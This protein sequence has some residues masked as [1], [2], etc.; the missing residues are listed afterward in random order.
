M[1]GRWLYGTLRR[2]WA[3]STSP[4]IGHALAGRPVVARRRE[5]P[6]RRGQQGRA[7]RRQRRRQDDPAAADRRR[8]EPA[9]RERRPLGRTRRDAP[10]HRLGARRHHR[11]GLPRPA[12]ACASARGLGRR[13]GCR[14][15]AHGPRRRAAP[16]GLRA[17]PRAL[18]RC[19]RLRRRGAVGHRHRRGAGRAVRPRASTASWRPCPAASRSGSRSSLAA[20]AGRGAAARRARQLPRRPGQAVARGAAARDGQDRAVR[21]PRPRAARAGRRPDRHRRGRDGL[22]ARRRVR[23]LPRGADRPSTNGWPSCVGAGRRS[24]RG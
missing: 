5:L 23:V 12:G 7:G 17:R 1:P 10:V 13:A 14:A 3:T 8:P 2:S 21:Q 24:T 4:G 22:G 6:G 15:R 9:G 20:R 19:R 11:A 18:G 16:A